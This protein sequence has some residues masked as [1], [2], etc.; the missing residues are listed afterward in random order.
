M[1]SSSY[2]KRKK[3]LPA[4]IRTRATP[5]EYRENLKK[6][7]DLARR[8]HFKI[9][10]ITQMMVNS[11]GEVVDPLEGFY[12]ESKRDIRRYFKGENDINKYVLDRHHGSILGHRKIASI[13]FDYLVKN[14]YIEISSD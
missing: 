11:P 13:L 1:K 14:G 7:A 6:M 4:E 12:I 8:E 3:N 9:L 5:E 2:K 10:F